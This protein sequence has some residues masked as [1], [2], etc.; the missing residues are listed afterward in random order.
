[1][2][3][4][5]PV[6]FS[7]REVSQV[8]YINPA[9][10]LV[11]LWGNR[12]VDQPAVVGMQGDL[13]MGVGMFKDAK[14][15]AYIYF[16]L[17]FFQ[18]LSFQALFEVFPVL[19]FATREFPQGSQQGIRWALCDQHLVIFSMQDSC[20]NRVVR[21]MSFWLFYRQFS[22]QLVLKRQTVLCQRAA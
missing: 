12:T 10:G 22:S 8:C 3:G 13:E 20:S 18:N 16:T 2:L 21:R 15:I 17:K 6:D 11:D 14:L 5:H 19:T 7:H 1:M 9:N 4:D